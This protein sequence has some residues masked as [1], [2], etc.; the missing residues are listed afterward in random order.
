MA[1]PTRPLHELWPA[2]ARR[3]PLVALGELP[4]PVEPLTPLAHAVGVGDLGWVKRDDLS[5]PVYGGNKVRTLEALFAEA[6]EEGATDVWSTGAYGT[7]HGLAAALHAP[8]AGLGA[9]LVVFPQPRSPSALENLRTVVSLG[10]PLVALRHWSELPAAMWRLGRRERARGRRPFVMVPGG[11]TPRGALAYVSAGLELALQVAA[12][13]LPAPGTVVVGAGSTCTVAGLLVG[14][15]LAAQRGVGFRDA[16][17]RPA[18]PRVL[19]VRVVPWV[20]T[21]RARILSLAAR[22][23]RLL[24][25]LAGDPRLALDARTLGVLL[26]TSGRFL[27]AGYGLATRRGRRALE[28]FGAHAGIALDTTYSGKVAAAFL[29]LLRRAAGGEHAPPAQYPP[30]YLFWSTKSTAPLPATTPG[31][32]A[33]APE[34]LRRWLDAGDA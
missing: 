22:T 25:L 14:V 18:A 23:A 20:V 13:E 4:T 8:R 10:A 6:L 34:R 5:S 1:A 2:L 7:N 11:A 27:G 12:G 3:A 31:A 24:A 29:E 21:S 9:G 32:V 28:I 19:A 33:R 16:R 30:P 26:G 17:G 15:A